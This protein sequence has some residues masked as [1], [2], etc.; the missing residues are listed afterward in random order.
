MLSKW[1]G[2]INTESPF[3]QTVHRPFTP[4]S[5]FGDDSKW[6]PQNENWRSKSNLNTLNGIH[7]QKRAFIKL[8]NP[9]L[10]FRNW[11]GISSYLDKPPYQKI[12]WKIAICRDYNFDRTLL[13]TS[14]QMQLLERY[15]LVA[16]DISSALKLAIDALKPDHTSCSHTTK[17]SHQAIEIHAR[18]I[19]SHSAW[20]QASATDLDHVKKIKTPALFVAIATVL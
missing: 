19:S 20:F 9:F 18:K 5:I 8:W 16:Q 1:R 6:F 14:I 17:T 10:D 13:K 3:G 2:R 15:F 12:Q 11:S 7:V 4:I